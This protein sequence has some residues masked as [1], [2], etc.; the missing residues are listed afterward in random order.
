[1]LVGFSPN[2]AIE[3]GERIPGL[4]AETPYVVCRGKDSGMLQSRDD[5]LA[6]ARPAAIPPHDTPY[7]CDQCPPSVAFVGRS[8]AVQNVLRTVR[9]VGTSGLNPVLIL[10]ET[11]TGKELAAKV[12]HHWACGGQEPFVAVNCASLNANLLESE[13]FGH[14]KG[15]FTGADRD[16]TGLFELAGGGTLFLDE[17]SEIPPGLQAK[18]LRVLQERT[19]RKVGGTAEL[20]LEATV[21]ASSNR[22]LDKEAAQDAFRRDLY[23][24][25]AVL[26]I[27]LP[28]LRSPDRRSDIPLL[29]QYF[30]ECSRLSLPNRPVGFTP[31]AVARLMEH[32]WPGNVRELRNVVE[33]AI[34]LERGSHIAPGS[35]CFDHALP[36]MSGDFRPPSCPEA[37]SLE[38]AEREFIL[39][40]LKETGWQRNRAAALLGITRATLYAKLK[41]YDIK[42]PGAAGKEDPPPAESEEVF[43]PAAGG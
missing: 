33:R 23:Y 21:I 18:L 4:D 7:L 27:V 1:M 36:S 39:R 12:V 10:G 24:R 37:F 11:G 34:L 15:A 2:P 29:G 6:L 19:Y 35:L 5:A 22:P 38:T 41:R 32:P 14:V 17:V 25:L 8:A 42:A 9:A 30:L 40:A 20:P 28:P 26:P 43:H 3:P 16:K 31:E 13:L